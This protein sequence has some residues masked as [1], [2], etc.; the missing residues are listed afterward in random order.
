MVIIGNLTAF[1][2]DI[3]DDQKIGLKSTARLFGHE[4]AKLWLTGFA[5]CMVSGLTLVGHNAGH[6]WPYFM[7]VAACAAHLAWQ[8]RKE[9]SSMLYLP[10]W[11]DGCL[12]TMYCTVH[13]TVVHS[14]MEDMYSY[15]S[16]CVCKLHPQSVLLSW[17]YVA[18]AWLAHTHRYGV[19]L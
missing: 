7:T 16:M 9:L 14:C 2:Q 8:V 10:S 11:Y 1:T 13:T 3:D 12:Y 15:F 17:D 18:F 4:R 19:C 5:A 6:S